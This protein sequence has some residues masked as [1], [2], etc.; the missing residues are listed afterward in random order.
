MFAHERSQQRIVIAHWGP[1]VKVVIVIRGTVQERAIGQ[2]TP[3][4]TLLPSLCH[5]VQG[6]FKP[7][8]PDPP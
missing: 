6:G 8:P 2:I 1:A 3:P 7:A 4:L 5:W